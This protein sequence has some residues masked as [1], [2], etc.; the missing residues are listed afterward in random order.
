MA[1]CVARW[2]NHVRDD[3]SE[4][5]KRT[6]AARVG[7]RCSSPTCR[8]PTSGPQLDPSRSL[9]VGVASHITA[10]SPGG[11]RYDPTLTPDERR[12]S[13]NAIWLCQTCGKLVDNDKLRFTEEELRRWK[14][15]AE[16]EALHRIGKAASSADPTQADWSEEELVLLSAC[17]ED[18]EIFVYSTDETG[19]FVGAGRR[20]FYDQSD[21]A[22]AALYMDAL[23]SLRRR[24]LAA[25]EGGSLYQLTGRGFKVARALKKQEL[26]VAEQTEKPLPPIPLNRAALIAYIAG[27]PRVRELDRRIAEGFGVALDRR[28]DSSLNLIEKA[29]YFNIETV[30]QLD[31]IVKRLGEKAVLLSHYLRLDDKMTA[32]YSLD[33]VFDIMAAELGSLDAMVAYYDSL[34]MTLT[35]SRAWAEGILE[36]YEQI[37]MYDT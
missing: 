37:K 26:A 30:A 4:E 17:A 10:A 6:V 9:N 22:V 20:H 23:Y 15:D 19:K 16:N 27:S 12:H 13:D 33:F 34:K 11:P 3:F 7:Y 31:E 14:R 24:G 36:A 1:A 21:P 5:V 2:I 35:P 32:G 18:G 29:Q 8:A 25:L 28:E